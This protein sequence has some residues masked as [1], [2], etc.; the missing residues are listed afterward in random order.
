[1][2]LPALKRAVERALVGAGV[3]GIAARRTGT[4]A[5]ILAYHNVVPDGQSPAGD[6]SL[7]LSLQA[8]RQQLDVLSRQCDVAALEDAFGPGASSG[9][10]RVVI[11]FDD[12]YRGAVTCGVKEL[13]RRGMA[14]TIFVAPGLLGDQ[15]FWWDEAGAGSPEGLDPTHRDGALQRCR[16]EAPEVRRWLAEQGVELSPEL[17]PPAARSAGIEELAHAVGEHPGLTLGAHSWSHPNLAALPESR[18]A[19]EVGRPLEWLRPRFDRVTVPWLAYPY[20]LESPAV[21]RAAEAAGYAGALRVN[22]GRLAR[23]ARPSFAVPRMNV[24]SGLSADGFLLR[25]SGAFRQ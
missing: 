5:L 23:G 14:A 12:A 15:T 17:I 25:V 10:P 24:P 1:M 22:G 6:R 2:P 18:L 9:R 4:R 13:A 20:G 3:A 8:F 16:G 11:T 7:H 21:Q 19:D